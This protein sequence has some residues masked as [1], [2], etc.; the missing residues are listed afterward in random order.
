MA[1]GRYRVEVSYPLGEDLDA[2]ARKIAG[3]KDWA[4]GAGFGQRDLSFDFGTKGKAL[5]VFENIKS[6]GRFEVDF[7]ESK[8]D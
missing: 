4:S 5:A 6:D 1:I 3:K 8:D 7:W 2:I